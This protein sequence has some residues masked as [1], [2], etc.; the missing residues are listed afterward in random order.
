MSRYET[1]VIGTN[2]SELY[3]EFREER[4]TKRLKQY[5]TPQFPKLSTV[6]RQRFSSLYH[7]WKMGDSY[8]RL[9]AQYYGDERLWWVIAWYNEKPTESHVVPGDILAIPKPVEELVSFFQFGA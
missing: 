4:N 5:R 3:E 1:E 2:D 8:W 7:T 6:V 9:A